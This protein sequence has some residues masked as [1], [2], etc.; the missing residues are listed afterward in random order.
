MP[1]KAPNLTS[2]L[3]RAARFSNT[4]RAATRGPIPYSKRVVR[5]RV[6]GAVNRQVG[7]TVRD[8]GL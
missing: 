5:R 1:R 6:Y 4:L 7:R 2:Q 3:Y 8:F